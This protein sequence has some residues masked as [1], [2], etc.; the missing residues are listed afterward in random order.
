MYN[1]S[2]NNQVIYSLNTLSDSLIKLLE[3]DNLNDITIT[4]IC[5][6][7]NLSRKTF[8]RNCESKIDLLVYKI[9]LLINTL[10]TETDWFSS[11]ERKLYTNF[12]NYWYKQKQF[13][14]ILKKNNLFYLFIEHFNK[15]IQQASYPFLDTLLENAE[16]KDEIKLYY[17][18]FL[19]GGLSHVLEQW[20]KNCFKISIDSLVNILCVLTP[21]H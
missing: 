5:N 15:I 13:L 18:T 11:D 21:N 4:E 3:T 6:S 12:F 16:N 2:K 14:S 17:N 19:V 9:D 10:Q 1:K 8:Y 20:T 7:T